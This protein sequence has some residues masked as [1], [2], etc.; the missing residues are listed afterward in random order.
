MNPLLGIIDEAVE[1]W[2]LKNYPGK[3]NGIQFET[4]DA[5]GKSFTW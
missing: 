3:F 5:L 1:L 2:N 4:E